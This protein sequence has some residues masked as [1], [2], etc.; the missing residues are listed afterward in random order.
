MSI[1]AKLFTWRY[2]INSKRF[3][4]KNSLALKLEV[5]SLEEL[6]GATE[7]LRFHS[8]I[9]NTLK[10]GEKCVEVQ[11]VDFDSK[12]STVTLTTSNLL[13]T[14]ANIYG[15]GIIE[16]PAIVQPS[17]STSPS[18][19]E[20]KLE[21]NAYFNKVVAHNIR[22]RASSLN[23]SVSLFELI[24]DTE[25]RNEIIERIK[26]LSEQ[27]SYSA[28]VISKAVKTLHNDSLKFEVVSIPTV[29]EEVLSLQGNK[30]S[31]LKAVIKTDFSAFQSVIFNTNYLK[32]IIF[33][34]LDNALKFSKPKQKPIVKIFTCIKDGKRHLYISDEGL[35]L[36]TVK[37]KD[38][39][40]KLNK[41]FHAIPNCHGTGL[42][43]SKIMAESCSAN[44]SFIS[45]PNEGATLILTFKD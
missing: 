8:V 31:Q 34:L 16:E 33:N 30:I 6:I 25:K 22:S 2:N 12:Q 1:T 5:K 26:E 14:S 29:V 23:L 4:I 10:I 17:V 11:F 18:A 20:K 36:D 44:L 40:F 38:N 32:E 45:Q 39:L 41:C 3:V 19:L 28:E 15:H 21:T 43:L 7:A 37:F 24:S 27:F 35:G 42:F 9:M 13:K